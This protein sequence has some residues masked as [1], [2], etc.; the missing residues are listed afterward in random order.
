MV[1]HAVV[2]DGDL[3]VAVAV[4]EPLCARVIEEA[5]ASDIHHADRWRGLIAAAI[6]APATGGPIDL[7]SATREVEVAVGTASVGEVM[8]VGRGS[9]GDIDGACGLIVNRHATADV[10]TTSLEE[11]HVAA[12]VD[13]GADRCRSTVDQ[14]G[15]GSVSGDGAGD[16]ERAAVDI[17]VSGIRVRTAEGERASASLGKAEGSGAA[18]HEG[19]GERGGGIIASRGECSRS[20]RVVVDHRTRRTGKGTDGFGKAVDAQRAGRS[21]IVGRVGAERRRRRRS[22]EATIDVGLAVVSAQSRT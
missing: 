21:H 15:R 16:I 13:N 3:T 7:V 5:R 9:R 11:R 17:G 19:A 20:G 4:D 6:G 10:G 8:L 14:D 18:V 12:H 22:H 2:R 1:D